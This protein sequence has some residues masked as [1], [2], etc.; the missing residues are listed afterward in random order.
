MPGEKNRQSE[1]K[2][3]AV[4]IIGEIMLAIVL[5][6]YLV[7]F[8]SLV[9]PIDN[10]GLR[11]LINLISIV[12]SIA[13]AMLS[14]RAILGIPSA[15]PESWCTVVRSSVTLFISNTVYGLLE[16]NNILYA[17]FVFPIELIGINMVVVLAIMF[18]PSVRKYYTPALTNVPPIKEWVKFIFY[19]PLND[20]QEYRFGY[21]GEEV[22]PEL[23][24]R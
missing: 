17:G 6:R 23:I 2:F 8:T 15:R 24:V 21:P 18:L 13:M 11:M 20:S 1:K 4:L 22:D 12:F 19:L 3:P 5:F 10:P 7:N 14:V 9:S 16:A